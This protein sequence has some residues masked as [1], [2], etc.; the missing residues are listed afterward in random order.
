MKG[1][2]MTGRVARKGKD[3]AAYK[4]LIENSKGK[5][6]LVRLKCVWSSTELHC[7]HTEWGCVLNPPV[8]QI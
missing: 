7:Q 4:V 6:T 1:D 5:I 3:T 2:K 8:T